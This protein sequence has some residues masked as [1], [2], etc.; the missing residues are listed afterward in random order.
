MRRN[1]RKFEIT[2]NSLD[3]KKPSEISPETGRVIFAFLRTTLFQ[4]VT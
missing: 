2:N 3:P 1:I 4:R